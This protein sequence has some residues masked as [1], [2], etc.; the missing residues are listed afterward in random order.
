MK[1]TV[2]FSALFFCASFFHA[3][4]VE[5]TIAYEN[6]EQPP[7]YMGN[8]DEVISP[9]PGVSVEMVKMLEERIPGLSIRLVR[10]PWRRCTVSLGENLVDGIFNASYSKERLVIGWY[11]TKDHSHDGLEDTDRRIA[12]ITYSLY[13]LKDSKLGWDGKI[14]S[15]VH[16]NIGAPLGYS[17][18]NDLRKLNVPVEEAPSTVNNLDKLLMGR[19]AAVALQDVTADKIIRNNSKYADIVKVNPP[20]LS[21]HYYLMLSHNFVKANPDLAQKIWDELKDIRN[22]SFDKIAENYSE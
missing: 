4:A 1:K 3:N 6:K 10:Y 14:F 22:T 13:T 8:S 9:R 21:K 17:V 5:M 12:T 19:V 2:V 20:F 16:G 11:P 15:G 7:Y 18:V